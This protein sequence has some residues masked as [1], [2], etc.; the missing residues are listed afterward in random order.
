[1]SDGYG[2]MRTMK[3]KEYLHQAYR[4]VQSL[5]SVGGRRC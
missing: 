3:A 1:M 2:A 5:I 4:Q